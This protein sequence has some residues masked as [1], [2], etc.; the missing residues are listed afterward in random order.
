MQDSRMMAEVW[1][2]GVCAIE[3]VSGSRIATPLAPPR[4]GSTPMITPSRM[5][6]SISARL[7][8]VRA[9]AKPWNSDWMSSITVASVQAE[10]RLERPLG[11]RH[12][13]PDL[14]DEEEDHAVAD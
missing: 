7:V 2:P 3:K 14:E 9:T 8:S 5:P 13:E 4:P 11:Q 12:E 6:N 1:P 10:Q